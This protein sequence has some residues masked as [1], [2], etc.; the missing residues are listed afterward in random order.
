MRYIKY[1]QL[2]DINHTIKL[3]DLPKAKAQRRF[4]IQSDAYHV[5]NAQ[6]FE[7][8]T[9]RLTDFE[10]KWNLIESEAVRGFQHDI[11]I[12][13]TFYQ[14]DTNLHS[15]IR[16]INHLK[17]LFREFRTKTDEIGTF[18]HETSCLTLFFVVVQRDSAK[19]N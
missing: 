2:P 4:K 12:S 19:H 10:Q 17:R 5:F 13:L 14:F 7:E 16:T 9:I 15:H 6:T 11:N 3:K 1:Q 8:A 18:P